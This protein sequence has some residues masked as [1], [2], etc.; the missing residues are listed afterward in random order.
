MRWLLAALLAT[1][2][3]LTSA[4][5][6]S[7]TLARDKVCLSCHDARDKKIG[8][9]FRDIAA[10]YANDKDAPARLAAKIMN[11]GAGAWGPVPMPANPKVTPQE[12]RQLATWILGQRP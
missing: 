6:A 2:P 8:P 9:A 10:R 7:P 11:G 3:L 12:A 1:G 5:H 4:A